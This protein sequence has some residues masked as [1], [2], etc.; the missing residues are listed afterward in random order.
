MEELKNKRGM[1]LIVLV[2][3]IILMIIIAGAIILSLNS[4]GII[5]RAHKA[6]TETEKSILKE[7]VELLLLRAQMGE[8]IE[9]IFK[10]GTVKKDGLMYE[11]SYKGNDFLV[12]SDYKYIEKVEE[13][14]KGEWEFNKSTQTLTK[15][16]G[17]LKT[18][19]GNQEVG[20]LIIPNYYDGVRVKNIGNSLFYK[21]TD[22]EKLVISEGIEKTGGS[23]FL[24]L[25]QFKIF[26]TS[27]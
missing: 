19:R 17:D 21:N 5:E 12:T 14:Y 24:R 2:I 20:E 8:S 6:K 7:E 10:T 4:S 3:T 11:V 25:F 1:S 9:D 13:E 22:L 15:Y 18:K 16:N 27:R 26:R 23:S